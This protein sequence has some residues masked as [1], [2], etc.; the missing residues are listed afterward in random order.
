M[1][2]LRQIQ[3]GIITDRPEDEIEQTVSFC[4]KEQDS[5]NVKSRIS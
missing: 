3:S 5:N 2:G 4:K 1:K